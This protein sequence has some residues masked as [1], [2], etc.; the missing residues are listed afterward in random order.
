MPGELVMESTVY[1]CTFFKEINS[2]GDFHVPKDNQ[3]ASPHLIN[4][5]ERNFFLSRETVCFR[6]MD[7]TQSDRTVEYADCFSAEG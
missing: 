4:H 1:I 7:S 2:D 3:H 5:F 6:F